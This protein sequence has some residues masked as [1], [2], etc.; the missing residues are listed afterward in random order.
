MSYTFNT[1]IN[2]EGDLAYYNMLIASYNFGI[3]EIRNL[4]IELA[5][6]PTSDKMADLCNSITESKED[7]STLLE[8]IENMSMEIIDDMQSLNNLLEDYA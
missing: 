3:V 8:E 5:D 6:C 4:L 1:V 2:L 7:C